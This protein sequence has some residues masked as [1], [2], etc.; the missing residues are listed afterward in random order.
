MVTA[1]RLGARCCVIRR[2]PSVLLPRRADGDVTERGEKSSVRDD[3][4]NAPSCCSDR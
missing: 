1:D 4:S 2:L 3:R